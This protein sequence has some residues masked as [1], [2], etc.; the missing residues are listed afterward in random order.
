MDDFSGYDIDREV[1]FRFVEF[2][3]K[4]KLVQL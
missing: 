1:D 4:E 3:V 2:L